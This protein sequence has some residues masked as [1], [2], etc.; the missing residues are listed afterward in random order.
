MP[1]LRNVLA[2]HTQTPDTCWFAHW[3]GWPAAGAWRRRAPMFHL[4]HR[5]FLRFTGSLDDDLMAFAGDNRGPSLW[6]P[7]D[8]A[9]VVANEV[10]S[11]ATYIAGSRQLLDDLLRTNGLDVAEVGPNDQI[12]VD[13]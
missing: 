1:L 7:E 8:R 13:E 6:W 4:P 9:W 11:D 5:E 2:R 12:T 10:D 3:D